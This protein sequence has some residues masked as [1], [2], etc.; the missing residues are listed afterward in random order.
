M[1]LLAAEIEKEAKEREEAKEKEVAA[2]ATAAST[3]NPEDAQGTDADGKGGS[4]SNDDVAEDQQTA[5]ETQAQPGPSNDVPMVD[6][7]QSAA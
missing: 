2:A 6:A 4:V 5:M 7:D 3:T 1:L